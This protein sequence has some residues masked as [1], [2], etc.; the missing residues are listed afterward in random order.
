ML[1]CNVM[2]IYLHDTTTDKRCTVRMAFLTKWRTTT[3][4]LLGVP[5]NANNASDESVRKAVADCDSIVGPYASPTMDQQSRVQNLEQIS[6][7]AG[8]VAGTLFSQASV[9]GFD[10][11]GPVSSGNSLTVFPAL[12]KIDE[13]GRAH[14]TPMVFEQRKLVQI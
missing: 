5:G 3:A 9:W 2:Y 1:P 6:I 8:R 12:V 13:N 11:Q 7:R 14:G 4:Y 10:W